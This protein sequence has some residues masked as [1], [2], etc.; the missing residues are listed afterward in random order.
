MLIQ[1][2]YKKIRFTESLEGDAY[3]ECFSLLKKQKKLF[4]KFQKEI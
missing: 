2:Q 3:K 4:L 1:K